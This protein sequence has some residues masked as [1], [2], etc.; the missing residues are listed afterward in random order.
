[1]TNGAVKLKGTNAER[2]EKGKKCLSSDRSHLSG[3]EGRPGSHKERIRT[4]QVTNKERP[5]HVRVTDV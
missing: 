5:T 2:T 3:G 4:G 1:M